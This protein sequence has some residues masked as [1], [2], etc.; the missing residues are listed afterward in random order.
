MP[1]QV[2]VVAEDLGPKSLSEWPA[3]TQSWVSKG[4]ETGTRAKAKDMAIFETNN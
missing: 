4:E 1:A 3:K 2:K